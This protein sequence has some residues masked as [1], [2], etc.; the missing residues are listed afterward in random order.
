MSTETPLE[1]Q[2]EVFF[3]VS[4][5]EIASVKQAL[6]EERYDLLPDLIKDLHEADMADLIASLKK[7]V[8]AA[9]LEHTK[10]FLTPDV[11]TALDENLRPEV[12]EYLGTEEIATIVTSMESDDALDLIESLDEDVKSDVLRSLPAGE[13][14]LLEETSAYPEDSAGRLMRREIVCVP[15]FWTIEKALDFVHHTTDLPDHFYSIYVVDPRHQPIGEISLS[16]LMRSFKGDVVESVMTSDLDVIPVLKDQKEVVKL[17][18]HYGLVSAPVADQAGRIVG[19]ITIDDVVDIIEEE[20]EEDILH[21]AGVSAGDAMSVPPLTTAYWRIRWLIITL[22]NTLVASFVISQFQGS[23][24]KIT[25]L[26]FLMTINAAMGGNA[27][28]QVV[29]VIIRALATGALKESDTWKAVTKEISVACIT[30]LFFSAVLGTI[31]SFWVHDWRLGAILSCAVLANILWSA[32]AGTF[33]PIFIQRMG[34]DPAI[35]AGPLLTTTTDVLGYSIFLGL[36][37]LFLL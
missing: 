36:A 31:A 23:I 11:I 20:A 4:K 21:L 1:A 26:A 6:E 15:P 16:T 34:M 24:Q 7:D 35:S 27:G 13:R 10:E 8:R 19:M 22:T 32:V 33:L 37:T 5:D 29:T 30:G 17:F 28:M 18:R 25:A 14:A 9:F 2:E 12:M 3:G